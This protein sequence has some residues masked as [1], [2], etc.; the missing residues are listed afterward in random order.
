M[1][2]EPQSTLWCCCHCA[3]QGSPHPA[4]SMTPSAAP[5]GSATPSP[6][7]SRAFSTWQSRAGGREQSQQCWQPGSEHGM[8]QGAQAEC[9]RAKWM[10]DRLWARAPLCSVMHCCFT[11]RPL[12]Q[13]DVSDSMRPRTAPGRAAPDKHSLENNKVAK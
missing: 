6:A 12:R 9:R 4:V 7:S 5:S 1:V 13:R 2:T 8:G 10:Q 3:L 11:L